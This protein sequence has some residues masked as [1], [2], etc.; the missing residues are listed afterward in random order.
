ML[1][2]GWCHYEMS[3]GG[4]MVCWIIGFLFACTIL[5]GLCLIFT[6]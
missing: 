5:L 1:D 2:E 6:I 3:I 4:H